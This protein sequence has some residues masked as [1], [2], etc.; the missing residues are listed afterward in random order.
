MSFLLA[1]SVAV[2]LRAEPLSRADTRL[3]PVIA[4]A[5]LATWAVTS[6]AIAG[7]VTAAG[8]VVALSG[9][10]AAVLVVS[11]RRSVAQGEVLA[12]AVVAV[13]ALT[14]LTGWIGV[15]WRV[16][17]WALEDQGLWRGATT[18]G[19]ANAAAGLLTPL[20]LLA[21]A[22]LVSRP[23]APVDVGVICLL[24]VG[25]GATLSRG[26][27]V[28]LAAGATVLIALIGVR[29]TLRVAAPAVAGAVIVLA[30]LLPSMASSQP[31]RPVLAAAALVLGLGVAAVLTKMNTRVVGA[32]LA[33][34]VT[35]VPLLFVV[36][37]DRGVGSI[38]AVSR[39]RLSLSSPDRADVTRAVL[40]LAAERPVTGTGPGR[41]ILEWADDDGSRLVSRYAHNEYLQV[42]AE[43]GVVGLA[44]VLVLMAAF[45]RTLW[46]ARRTAPSA[47]LWAGVVAGSVALGVHSALDFLWHLPVVPLVGV[48]LIG[49]VT[50]TTF[51]GRQT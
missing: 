31:N 51:G 30:G 44:L 18:L 7:D 32:L 17:P 26:G 33:A 50:S 49:T 2:A 10:V 9:A 8:G 20:F 19:Y 3:G 1:A 37:E 6:A 15:A 12:A 36:A 21:L 34:A 24:L 38:D 4:C 16:S 13:G 39:A 45:A 5:A 28:A 35:V 43:L 47:Q 23:L 41:A 29:P 22:R 42:L 48:L 25:L 14:A 27:A 46:C 40:R 11:R